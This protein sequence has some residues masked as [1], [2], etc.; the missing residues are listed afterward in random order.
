MV[1][2]L[3]VSFVVRG[4]SAP[5]RANAQTTVLPRPALAAGMPALHQ[6]WLIKIV[7]EATQ[8]PKLWWP[9]F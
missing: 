4:T 5:L 8:Q 1:S 3:F 2:E 9:F 7:T 6:L